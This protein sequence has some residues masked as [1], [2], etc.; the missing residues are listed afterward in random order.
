MALLATFNLA[1]IPTGGPDVRAEGTYLQVNKNL[2]EACAIAV[3]FVFRTGSIA[4]LDRLWMRAPS[5]RVDVQ[6]AAV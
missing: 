4:G 1:A 5:A 2:I 3:V 6:E